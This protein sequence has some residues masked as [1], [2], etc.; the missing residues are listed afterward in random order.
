MGL[1]MGFWRK[2]KVEA[3]TSKHHKRTGD[4]LQTAI[5]KQE[6]INI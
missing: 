5:A 4:S 3:E 2:A 6:K 1:S